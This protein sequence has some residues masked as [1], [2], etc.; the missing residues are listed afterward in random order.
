VFNLAV[1]GA[2]SYVLQSLTVHNCLPRDNGALQFAGVKVGV[3][4]P[5]ANATNR[6][7]WMLLDSIHNKVTEL[8]PSAVGILGLSY[9]YGVDVD[10]AALGPWLREQMRKEGIVCF[11]YDEL[12]PSDP[13]EEVLAADVIVVTQPE[14]RSLIEGATA[15]VID[16]WR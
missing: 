9:K 16:L 6:V 4:L 8:K 11:G 12:M 13:L 5:L 1:E 15:E 3:H 7:N 14:Y 2:E 10:T